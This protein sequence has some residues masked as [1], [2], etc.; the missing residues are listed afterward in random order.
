MEIHIM[1]IKQSEIKFSASRQIITKMVHHDMLKNWPNA[2]RLALVEKIY[3][4]LE[5][6][7]QCHEDGTTRNLS[8]EIYK[9]EQLHCIKMASLKDKKVKKI[10]PKCGDKATE[11]FC[12]QHDCVNKNILKEYQK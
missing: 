8:M 5:F 4:H 6:C 1:M 2:E 3:N 10:C 11:V 9:W 12:S 7:K